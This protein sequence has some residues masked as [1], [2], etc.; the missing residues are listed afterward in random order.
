MVRCVRISEVEV[1]GRGNACTG[2]IVNT[3]LLGG[4]NIWGSIHQ[5]SCEHRDN[6]EFHLNT[7]MQSP[8]GNDWEEEDVQVQRKTSGGRNQDD[9]RR[10]A[11]LHKGPFRAR[12]LCDMS[13][14]EEVVVYIHAGNGK[15][16]APVDEEAEI[17]GK[18]DRLIR[19]KQT[20]VHQEEGR[21]GEWHG[22]D[23]HDADEE[24]RLGD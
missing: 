2:Q 22:Q 16:Q 15:K 11:T 7:Q 13:L 21:L 12:R 10:T 24:C 4:E 20:Q 5:S 9:I 6:S 14:E 19:R 17:D 23:G 1:E 3:S 8:Y 18:P